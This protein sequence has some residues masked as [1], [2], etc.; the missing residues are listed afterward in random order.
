LLQDEYSAVK[1]EL[2]KKDE[3][4]KRVEEENR[5]LVERWLRKVNEE[6]TKVNSANQ[7]YESMMEKAKKQAE[8]GTSAIS[9]FTSLLSGA[10]ASPISQAAHRE[11]SSSSLK[12]LQNLPAQ[13]PAN[14]PRAGLKPSS[15]PTE[16]LFYVSAH[17]SEV[18]HVAVSYDGKLYA[19][20]GSDKK[21]KIF[22]S[23]TGNLKFSLSGFLQSVMHVQ[24]SFTDD[25]ILA[26]SNDHSVKVW[27]VETGRP[28][29][30]LTGH[31]GNV[32][33]A[34][35][36]NDSTKIVSGSHDRTIK[37][38]DIQKG[39][40]AR[41]LFTYS[42]VND[43]CMTDDFG[44]V[45]GHVDSSVRFWDINSGDCIRE[46]SGIHAGQVT[47][48]SLCPDTYH[49]LTCSRDNTLKIMDIRTYAILKTF[50]TESFHV[51]YNFSRACFSSD[52]VYVAAGSQNGNIFIWNAKDCKLEKVL[53]KHKHPVTAVTWSPSGGSFLYSVDKD[54]H[55]CSWK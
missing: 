16:P 9:N 14:K 18:N 29:Y 30:T 3:T 4:M 8:A 32:W 10:F 22:E 38:W 21:I 37:V 20:G 36:S 44:I 39:S 26:C 54:R 34:R 7:M 15:L 46:L 42:S 2:D 19:T 43:L 24:F 49:I 48:V 5:V 55:V 35:F 50:T 52:G 53:T 12:G 47:S 31:I 6:A 40:C 45:S 28:K 23:G 11:A 17:E 13:D 41:T 33:S 1:L 27:N 51:P 25:S